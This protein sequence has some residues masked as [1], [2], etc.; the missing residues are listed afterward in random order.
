MWLP[1]L[2]VAFVRVGKSATKNFVLSTNLTVNPAIELG[3]VEVR[4]THIH[5]YGAA[6]I[7]K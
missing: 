4:Q 3:E 2:S 1:P 7:K 6:I 5:R